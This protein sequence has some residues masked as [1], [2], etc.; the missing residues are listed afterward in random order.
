MIFHIQNYNTRRELEE[1]V[2][3][4]VGTNADMNTDHTIIG[5]VQ[6][7]RNF[8]LSERTNIYGVRCVLVTEDL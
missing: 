2:K 4:Q 7:F 1:E 5:T 8:N 3:L 6:D